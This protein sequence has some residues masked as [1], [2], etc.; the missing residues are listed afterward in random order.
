MRRAAWMR[1]GPL[2]NRNSL[3]FLIGAFVSSIGSWMLT[4]ALGWTIFQLSNSTFLLGL[5]GF[6]QLAPVLLLGAVGGAL[7]DRIDRRR[8]SSRPRRSRRS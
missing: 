6:V 2:A 3:L 5:L 1:E 4:I 7:A 8:S